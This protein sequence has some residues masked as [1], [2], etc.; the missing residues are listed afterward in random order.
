MMHQ[1]AC[2]DVREQLEAFHDGELSIHQRLAVQNH[3]EDCVSCS[4]A[5]SEL[6]NLSSVLRDFSSEAVDADA[7]V[8]SRL[9]RHVLERVRV[10]EQFSIRAKMSDWFQDM[11]LVWAGLGASVATLVCIIGSASVLH[12]TSQ[13]RPNSMA[14]TL[15]VLAS[16]GSNDNPLRLSYSMV[17]P[18]AVTTAAIEM[19]EENAHYTLS[20]VVSRE[21]RVQGVEMINQPNRPGMNAML[22]D[23]YRMQFSPA[24]DRGDAVAV[25]MVW[26]LANTTVKGRPLDMMEVVREALRLHNSP[27][28]LRALPV[29]EDAAAPAPLMKPDTPE[30]SS[31]TALADGP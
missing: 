10:E 24:M 11:H 9:S 22:N 5:A 27:E 16:P 25:S 30:T 15:A 8:V 26:L 7:A 3:L 17:V 12:A 28:P 14:R 13:E 19:S 6:S 21:G 18:S 31:L 2:A 29:P 1:H 20:A 23:A 4:L